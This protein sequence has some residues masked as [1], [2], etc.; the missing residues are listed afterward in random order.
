MMLTRVE[1][2][3]KVTGIKGKLIQRSS[4]RQQYVGINSVTHEPKIESVDM[5]SRIKKYTDNPGIYSNKFE[6]LVDYKEEFRHYYMLEQS[7]EEDFENPKEGV[8]FIEHLFQVLTDINEVIQAVAIF[9]K[10][11]DTFYSHHVTSII[12]NYEADLT[13]ATILVHVDS[14]LGFFK[15]RMKKLY[16]TSPESFDFLLT[17]NTGL[18]PMLISAFRVIKVIIPDKIEEMSGKQDQMGAV[19][20]QKL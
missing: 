11:F 7:L 1:N 5:I 3:K 18:I 4:F 2:I 9:D 15:G 20:D 14:T 17:S 6:R 10:A 13:K 19:I 16:D 8:D 12:K